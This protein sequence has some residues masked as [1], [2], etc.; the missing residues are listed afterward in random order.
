MFSENFSRALDL[1]AHNDEERI[2]ALKLS[3]VMLQVYNRSVRKSRGSVECESYTSREIPGI[4]TSLFPKSVLL[5]IF[6]IAKSAFSEMEEDVSQR[7][8][9]KLVYVFKIAWLMYYFIFLDF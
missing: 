5:P 4:R 1:N 2:E 3:A 8:N 7:K 9:D 6:L